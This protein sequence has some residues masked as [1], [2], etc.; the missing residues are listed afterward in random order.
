MHNHTNTPHTVDTMAINTPIEILIG[1]LTLRLPLAI[2]LAS[3]VII[4]LLLGCEQ[5]SQSPGF[6]ISPTSGLI[7]TEN[8]GTVDFDIVLN[9]K[10][11][12]MVTISL[13]SSNTGEGILSGDQVSFSAANWSNPQSVTIT[14]V[15]D[16]LSDGDTVYH[17][18]FPSI[19]SDDKRYAKKSIESLMVINLDNEIAQPP[20]KPTA[21]V[22]V[23]PTVG[24][25]TS[26]NQTSASFS[27]LLTSP[28]TSE[29]TITA[30]S[31]NINEGV[32]SP[33]SHVFTGSNWDTAAVFT[34]TGVD[35]NVAD[36]NKQY[37]ITLT[38]QSS[39]PSYN[40]INIAAVQL[41]NLDNEVPG[42]TI[43]SNTP[44]E[45][46]ESGTSTSFTVVLN[47]LPTANVSISI[48]SSN[49]SEGVVSPANL[50]FTS[51]N[52]NLPQTV[53]VTGVDDNAV[54]GDINYDITFGVQS[55]D[56]YYSGM[57][58]PPLS[59][60]NHDNDS[61]GITINPSTPFETSENL[62][63]A[64]F[65]AV[66]HSLPSA[67]VSINITSSD[68]TEA[69]ASPAILTFTSSDWNNA[70]SVIVTGVDDS[71]VDGDISYN[72]S[73]SVQSTD[74]LYN[75]RAIASLSAVNLDND[76]N[77]P[78]QYS[79]YIKSGTIDIAASTI[80]GN[81]AAILPSLG[82]SL[83]N[84]LPSTTP[85]PTIEAVEGQPVTINVTNNHSS[86]HH[87]S[88][89]GLLSNPTELLP[90]ETKQF[91]FTATQAG[92]YRYAD[93]QLPDRAAGRPSLVPRRRAYILAPA[94]QM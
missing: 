5:D 70:Q 87:F 50:T 48:A 21:G 1:H 4:L 49:T 51:S 45:T 3:L 29:V 27:V 25:V 35:D 24:L 17:I 33:L 94:N 12:A 9:T 55:S 53:T 2:M 42:I 92:V 65:T 44:L 38:A 68:P 67:N 23:V 83:S 41:Q 28:P 77:P 84:S 19:K 18:N 32:V 61:P 13:R 57:A 59:A 74:A 47:S 63:T 37:S 7:T 10:P 26:E 66:L 6:T 43:N 93:P 15:D 30:V 39:D 78:K 80:T 64:T 11:D 76:T 88:I 90:G 34:V 82:F 46:F 36:G 40:G 71:E 75:D 8:G 16:N 14:G 31:S 56:T 69:T 89:E 54:D 91:Q 72:I 20:P 22:T 52:W 81:G 85:G 79:L 86:T 73:F 60:V 58:I 62:T